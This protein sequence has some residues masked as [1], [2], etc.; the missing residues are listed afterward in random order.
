MEIKPLIAIKYPSMKT[1]SRVTINHKPCTFQ[2]R[3]Q[4]G[5]IDKMR[6]PQRGR[7]HDQDPRAQVSID[8]RLGFRV[9]APVGLEAAV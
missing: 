7:L 2:N 6:R 3:H 8:Q 1:E 5:R 4:H 9:R